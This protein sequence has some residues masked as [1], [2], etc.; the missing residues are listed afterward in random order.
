MPPPPGMTLRGGRAAN[1]RAHPSG[2]SVT[3][4]RLRLEHDP[5]GRTQRPALGDDRLVRVLAADP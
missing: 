4:Q 2:A 1:L 3:R 5:E